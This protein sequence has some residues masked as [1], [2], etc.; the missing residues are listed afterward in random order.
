MKRTCPKCGA[1]YKLSEI[2]IMVR[3][4]DSLECSFCN[5]TIIKWDGSSF[6]VINEVIKKPNKS[7]CDK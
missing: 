4:Q 2:K 7:D 1:V 5:E 3:D 6:W